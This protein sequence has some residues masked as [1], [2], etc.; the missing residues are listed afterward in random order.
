MSTKTLG[1]R[2]PGGYA[3]TGYGYTGRGA[4]LG[5]TGVF[6]FFVWSRPGYNYNY[7]NYCDRYPSSESTRCKNY[8]KSCTQEGCKA[9]TSSSMTRD[10]LLMT[11]FDTAGK[12]GT[13][14]PTWP[15]T[16]T[17]HKVAAVFASAST[18]PDEWNQPIYFGFS[19]VNLD[20]EDGVPGWLIAIIVLVCIC[21]CCGIVCCCIY[22]SSENSSHG[23]SWNQQSGIQRYSDDG[24]NGVAMQQYQWQQQAAAGQPITAPPP[25]F[26]GMPV[27]GTVVSHPAAI[28]SHPDAK[29]P[30]PAPGQ[31]SQAWFKAKDAATGDFYWYNARGDV[32]WDNPDQPPPPPD[33]P[34]PAQ[35]GWQA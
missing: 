24:T 19:E 4:V 10:D 18:E 5:G 26:T 15:L 25:A 22:C 35:G 14:K 7:Y 29:V 16:V 34:P 32:T 6:L 12:D 30:P 17:V 20:D 3:R 21:T 33:R 2:Y 1:S 27:T 9:T 31:T 13:P 23:Q 11:S 8:Y 28:I